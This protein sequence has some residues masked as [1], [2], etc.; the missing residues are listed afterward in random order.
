[1]LAQ[2]RHKAKISLTVHSDD[3]AFEAQATLTR[4][5]KS[6]TI[7]SDYPSPRYVKKVGLLTIFGD[8]STTIVCIIVMH[9]TMLT[10]SC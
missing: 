7:K 4:L 10:T 1:M 3:T 2:E 8:N 6:D 9:S 5:S